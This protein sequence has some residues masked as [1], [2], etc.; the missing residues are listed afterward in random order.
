MLL[1]MVNKRTIHTIAWDDP[2]VAHL[3]ERMSLYRDKLGNMSIE[4]Q[5]RLFKGKVLA[6]DI[7]TGSVI[8]S[9]DANTKNVHALLKTAVENSY[10]PGSDWRLVDGPTGDEPMTI[11]E[12]LQ[13]NASEERS[14][15]IDTNLGNIS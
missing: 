9:V 3:S 5:L 2:R 4:E 13:Y 12:L 1:G 14:E 11:D 8:A 10:F 15:N 7:L 6:I